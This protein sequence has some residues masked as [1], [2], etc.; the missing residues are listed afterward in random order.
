MKSTYQ[1]W[2]RLLF[3]ATGL[4][5][6]AG[7]AWA[8]PGFDWG[9]WREITS[10]TP[11]EIISPQAG[12]QELAPLLIPDSENNADLVQW[13]KRRKGIIAV[14]STLL[15]EP[16]GIQR[17]KNPPQ[18]G[19]PV[20]Q[21]GYTRT[22]V[23]IP[24]ESGDPITAYLLMPD[25]PLRTP[26]PVMIVLHQTQAPGKDEACGLTGDPEMAFAVELVQRGY[27]CVA[28]DVIGFGGR[29]PDGAE[30]YHGAHDFYR[31]H[32]QWSFFGKM[33][34]DLSRV[35]DYIESLDGADAGRIGVIG[36]SHGA[37]GALMGAA[38]EPRIGAV[39]ASCGFTTL[40]MD[41]NPERWSHLTALLPRLGFYRDEISKAPF[42]W[43]EVLACIAPR[44]L[45]NWATLEDNIFPNTENL[46]EVYEQ[47]RGVYA[48]HDTAPHFEG[49]LVPG[50]HAF[51][52][53]AR[54]EAYTW[55]DN[56]LL[57]KSRAK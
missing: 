6:W 45:F 8:W 47:V 33:N 57:I 54:E 51:P 56:L 10:V 23:L 13:E 16:T 3:V 22:S 48:L 50:G 11:P 17:D 9:T 30:P 39:I 53:E 19:T 28:P 24:G 29:T 7:I 18:T 55:L 38:F 31:R 21:A 41:P 25:T 1:S 14:L 5:L 15:G 40:R 20:Q 43:H 4:A 37:Y 27:I 42:D 34:W 2:T 32:P 12:V 35:V 44:P 52:K 46:V 49:R 36:H 26:T